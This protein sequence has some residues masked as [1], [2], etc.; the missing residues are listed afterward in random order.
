[1]ETLTSRIVA[2]KEEAE[3]LRK[4]VAAYINGYVDEGET[5]IYSYNHFTC[6][7]RSYYISSV[8]EITEL[9]PNKCSTEMPTTIEGMQKVAEDNRVAQRCATQALL[10]IHYLEL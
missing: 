1:M 10:A 5:S 9:K 8:V 2:N 4:E 6:R 3:E 7:D